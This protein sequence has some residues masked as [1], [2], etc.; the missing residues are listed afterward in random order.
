LDVTKIFSCDNK[1]SMRKLGL[2]L[3]NM[4]KNNPI[5][6]DWIKSYHFEKIIE[7]II[8]GLIPELY[9]NYECQVK[10]MPIWQKFGNVA[11]KYYVAKYATDGFCFALKLLKS[12]SSVFDHIG[13]SSQ[14]ANMIRTG[15]IGGIIGL[16]VFIICL[17]MA[18]MGML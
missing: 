1:E 8:I 13:G 16:L 5:L 4:N 14:L 11:G 15:N 3:R 2:T 12:I 10:Q 17:I 7:S 9:K 6:K 18:F